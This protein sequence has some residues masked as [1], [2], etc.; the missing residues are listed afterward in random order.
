MSVT[1]LTKTPLYAIKRSAT[2]LGIGE[3]CQW[4]NFTT[5]T[6]EI[7]EYPGLNHVTESLPLI[8]ALYHGLDNYGDN[9]HRSHIETL[10]LAFRPS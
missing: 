2:L 1:L 7:T 4:M 5:G 6:F 8:T 9:I 10:Y 3:V